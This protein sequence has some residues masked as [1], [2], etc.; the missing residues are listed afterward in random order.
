M[1]SAIAVLKERS[2]TS[3]ICAIFNCWFMQCAHYTMCELMQ[4]WGLQMNH[5]HGI[6]N[7]WA[8]VF[9]GNRRSLQ[10]YFSRFS[11]FYKKIYCTCDMLI[12]RWSDNY[13]SYL[14]VDNKTTVKQR[15]VSNG[16]FSSSLLLLWLLPQANAIRKC[17]FLS[18]WNCDNFGVWKV[19]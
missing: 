8:S 15:N 3:S 12:L 13:S 4:L 7:S 1:A 14:Y 2:H 18:R 17:L 16:K 19:W 6:F 5:F 10:N 11:V 9:Q